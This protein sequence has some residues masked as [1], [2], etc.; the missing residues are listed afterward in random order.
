MEFSEAR[1]IRD[2]AKAHL[3]LARS[4]TILC[5]GEEDVIRQTFGDNLLTIT[6]ADLPADLSQPQTLHLRGF[7]E[8]AVCWAL[9]RGKPLASRSNR[10][11]A[12]LIAN[13]KASGQEI[14][15]QLSKTAGGVAGN[16]AGLMTSPTDEHPKAEQ[17]RWAEA[18]HVSLDQKNGRTWLLIEPDIWIWP[19]RSRPEATALLDKRRANRFNSKHDALLNDWI[20]IVLETDE[21]N[22]DVTVRV[23]DGESGAG[24]PA[25]RVGTR[26]AFSR[27]RAS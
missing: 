8:E 16:V 4:Q 20:R 15:A 6:P 21:R 11:G 22:A 1:R 10:S 9:A 5:W 7:V 26:T 19:P 3:I 23:F 2:D 12:F 14:F 18:L 13:P 25:F 27:R 24:N 17:V